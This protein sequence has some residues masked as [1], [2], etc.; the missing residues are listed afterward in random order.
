MDFDKAEIQNASAA[1]KVS[2][3]NGGRD[4]RL[5]DI[6]GCSVDISLA[7]YAFKYDVLPIPLSR[8]DWGWHAVYTNDSSEIIFEIVIE[9][10]TGRYRI[11]K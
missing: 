4:A 1:L 8:P 9:P 5:K 10:Y 3:D 7:P 2:E 11:E 6:N